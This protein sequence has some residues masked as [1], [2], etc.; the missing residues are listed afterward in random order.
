VPLVTVAQSVAQCLHYR[1]TETCIAR[2]R[3][4]FPIRSF[5]FS[6]DL[7]FTPQ[8]GSGAHSASNEIFLG[9]KRGW[10]V[11]PTSPPSMSRLSTNYG[12]LDVSQPY[13][14]PL[15]VTGIDSFAF[16]AFTSTVF[17]EMK[18]YDQ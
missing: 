13:E 11:R 18:S 6:I 1:P 14:P 2:S 16:Y 7:I 15:P 12:S 9:V 5:H 3:A 4:R 10:R 17:I 8:R